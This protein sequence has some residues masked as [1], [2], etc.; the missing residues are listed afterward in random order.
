MQEYEV[1]LLNEV[2]DDINELMAFYEEIAGEESALRFE[3]AIRE[4]INSL[5][6]AP[7][8]NPIWQDNDNVRRINMRSHKVAV[9]YV[10]DDGALRVVAVKAFHA[11]EN[12]KTYR[13]E[14]TQRLKHVE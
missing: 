5:D 13:E 2:D 1:R 4:V 9:V 10:V 3:G 11:L 8:G 7:K 14:I 6:T 12:P